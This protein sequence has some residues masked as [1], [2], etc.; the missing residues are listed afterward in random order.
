MR[1]KSKMSVWGSGLCTCARTNIGY[2]FV[3][4]IALAGMVDKNNG[5]FLLSGNPLDLII[6]PGNL[7][8]AVFVNISRQRL[9]QC[10]NDDDIVMPGLLRLGLKLLRQLIKALRSTALKKEFQP[11]KIIIRKSHCICDMIQT[12]GFRSFPA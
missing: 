2:G 5:R 3:R 9:V 7:P 6:D 10:V 12:A 4:L 1:A 8:V 11:I